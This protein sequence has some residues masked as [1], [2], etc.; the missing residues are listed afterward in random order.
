METCRASVHIISTPG[1]RASSS[2]EPNYLQPQQFLPLNSPTPNPQLGWQNSG[3]SLSNVLHLPLCCNCCGSCWCQFRAASS[4]FSYICSVLVTVQLT[5]RAASLAHS[6]VRS[7]WG[8]IVLWGFWFSFKKYKRNQILMVTQNKENAHV[9]TFWPLL[10][11]SGSAMIQSR[12][13]NS[14]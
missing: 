5:K 3:N 9:I 4:Q 12:P 10:S 6:P 13:F 2:D 8:L 1:W 7:H 14:R 11:Q